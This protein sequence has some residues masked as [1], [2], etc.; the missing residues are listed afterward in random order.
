M[1]SATRVGKRISEPPPA[2]ELMPPA[3]RATPATMTRSTADTS[4]KPTVGALTLRVSAAD[5]VDGPT[6]PEHEA[7]DAAGGVSPAGDRAG[8]AGPGAEERPGRRDAGGRGGAA[9]ARLSSPG[10]FARVP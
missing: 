5:G 3:R 6:S 1:P 9:T 2:I 4:G 8:W 7:A 10:V